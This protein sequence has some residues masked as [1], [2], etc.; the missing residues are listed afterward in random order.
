MTYFFSRT[1]ITCTIAPP[2]PAVSL[3]VGSEPL[4]FRTITPDLRFIS[5]N[6]SARGAGAP[7]KGQAVAI[8]VQLK[9][10]LPQ[11]LFISA[12]IAQR[13]CLSGREGAQRKRYSQNQDEGSAHVAGS[14]RK[15]LRDFNPTCN[16]KSWV[17]SGIFGNSGA[18]GRSFSDQAQLLAGAEAVRSWP[19]CRATAPM[20]CWRVPIAIHNSQQSRPSGG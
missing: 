1:L 15:L 6:L 16:E 2:Y 8:A 13:T 4:D 18:S 10:L 3:D 20:P 14:H 5:L 9:F 17:F 19:K 12:E 11:T 7:V